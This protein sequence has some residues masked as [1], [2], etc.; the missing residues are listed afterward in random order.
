MFT[1]TISQ[2]EKKYL[3]E[4][5]ETFFKTRF[6]FPMFTRICKYEG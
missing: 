2:F 5:K 3:M 4:L 1:Y 6:D